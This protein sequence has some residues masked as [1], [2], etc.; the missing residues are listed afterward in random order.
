MNRVE[1]QKLHQTEELTFGW[2]CGV[3]LG[4]RQTQSLINTEQTIIN[5]RSL[6]WIHHI[7]MSFP[8]AIAYG[9]VIIS[10]RLQHENRQLMIM[11]LLLNSN[12]VCQRPSWIPKT[13][14]N[15]SSAVVWL[16]FWCSTRPSADKG[17]YKY[18]AHYHQLAIFMLKSSW[19]DDFTIGDRLW[20]THYDMKTSTWQ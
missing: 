9:G 16:S 19:Y 13:H 8:L 14:P 18:R 1:Q 12:W 6:W 15:D 7:M 11:S 5:K 4:F 3:Q 10:W 2:V 17:T 20:K